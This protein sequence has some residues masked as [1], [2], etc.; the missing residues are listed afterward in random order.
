MLAMHGDTN[1][2]RRHFLYAFGPGGVLAAVLLSLLSPWWPTVLHAAK[3]GAGQ[4]GNQVRIIVASATLTEEPCASPDA[5]IDPGET[6]TVSFALQNTGTVSTSQQL[7]ATLLATGGVTAPSAPQ[8]YGALLA[9]GY[10]VA[11]SF[12]FT[13]AAQE[14]G[15]TL[16]ATFQLKD[17]NINRGTAS[18]NFTLGVMTLTTNPG[19]C[20][21]SFPPADQPSPAGSCATMHCQTTSRLPF[22]VG[23]Y[24]L[25]CV[26]L[27]GTRLFFEVRVLDREPPRLTCPANITRAADANQC[28][29]TLNP[30]T[31]TAGDNCIAGLAVAGT[32]S[33][34]QPLT[35]AYP[36][37]AT[38]ISWQA[39]DAA[40]NTTACQQTVTVTANNTALTCP[41][42]ISMPAASGAGRVV[43]YPL[44][45]ASDACYGGNTVCNPASGS[46]FP[47]GTTTVSCQR[48]AT[49][50]QTA[51]CAFTV[52]VIENT[53]ANVS[54]ASFAGAE[55]ASE[56]IVAAFGK[57][58]ATSIQAA[59]V[60]PLPATL[61]GTQVL[62]RDSAGIERAAPLFFVSPAQINYQVPAG[63]A[64][65]MATVLVTGGDGTVST[66]T[67]RIASVAPGLFAADASGRGL[68]AATVLRVRADGS[69]NFEPVV[70]F[71]AAQ[72]KF[73]AVP[74]DLGPATD[75]VFLVLFGTGL[76]FHSSLSAVTAKIGGL[77]ATVVFAG[78]AP[79]VGLDQVNVS[80]PRNLLGRG[81]VDVGLTVDGKAANTV[82][83]NIK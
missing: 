60:L 29:A 75:Q 15:S 11:R 53:V 64:G 16:T 18:I 5:V 71:D 55:L 52:S 32:R 79:G 69:Q 30:G 14:I 70:T 28:A 83:V 17:G 3:P 41:A 73:V 26:T 9:G 35:A 65:G 50:G 19:Q 76:R 61:A 44:P 49:T 45:A 66:G 23:N 38:T 82:Q 59:S 43:T 25:N 67:V 12:S 72:N 40:N 37:G 47:V 48:T 74:L 7:V 24:L 80:L 51:S 58:L 33:D 63:T 20:Y 78:T 36:L 42:N 39:S 2:N 46:T 62:V 34:N 57:G 1:C 10:S 31:A 77:D 21:A 68:A 27:A 54:A 22:P 13:A 81:E 56:S 8:N 4:A 6:V